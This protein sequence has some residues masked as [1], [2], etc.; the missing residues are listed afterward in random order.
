LTD[1]LR[2]LDLLAQGSGG[3]DLVNILFIAI[4]AILWLG[5]G[6]IKAAGRNRSQQQ[7]EGAAQKQRPVRETWQQ[8]LARKA[9]EIQR[10][11]EAKSKETAE[12]M[13]RMQEQGRS[14]AASQRP[15]PAQP[16]NG[17]VAIRSGPRGESIMVYEK[18]GEQISAQQQEQIARQREARE[19]LAA[20]RRRQARVAPPVEPQIETGI[21]ELG[22]M[23]EGLGTVTPERPES[24]PRRK[25][26]LATQ[27]ESAGFQPSELIDYADSDA[28]KKAILHYEIFGKPLALRDPSAQISP[29]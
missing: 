15:R 28:L 23:R 12:R 13:R 5:G 19:A 18:A 22:T 8:R 10:A 27:H 17:K 1:L 26:R 11:A 7:R 14:P 6:L 3:E 16:P 2:Q 25:E 9:E 4:M 20:A 29:F 24:L 21:P